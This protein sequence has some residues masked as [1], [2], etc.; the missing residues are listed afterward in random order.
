MART[1][2]KRPQQKRAKRLPDAVREVRDELGILEMDIDDLEDEASGAGSPSPE[3][4]WVLRQKAI[5]ESAQALA[6]RPDLDGTSASLLRLIVHLSEGLNDALK[7]LTV[8]RRSRRA[9]EG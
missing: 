3:S 5:L 9:K 7:E 2:S 1:P 4:V 6:K 8:I